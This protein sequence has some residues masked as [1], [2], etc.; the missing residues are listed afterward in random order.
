MPASAGGSADPYHDPY[1]KLSGYAKQKGYPPQ[2]N[3]PGSS[4]YNPY[5]VNNDQ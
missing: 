3:T 5:K 2:T 1:D 4:K